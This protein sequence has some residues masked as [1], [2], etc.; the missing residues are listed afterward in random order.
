MPITKIV[1][2]GQTGADQ[3]ALEAAVYCSLPY[4]GWIPKGRK[5]EKGQKV[6]TKFDQLREMMTSDYL[7]RTE[8]NVVDSDATLVLTYGKATGGSKKTI[9]FAEKH[10]KPVL[11]IGIDQYSPRDCAMFV[12]RWFEGD[13]TKPTPPDNCTLN[14]AGSRESKSPGIQHDVMN[15]I[16]EVIS[17]VNGTCFY[18]IQRSKPM[19][20][21][22]EE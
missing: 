3:G 14:V 8:A 17:V 1:S 19:I 22:E 10:G 9:E 6:P 16:I 18:P 4:G 13:I 15:V 11:H 21:R 2:G 20:L 5:A 12:K 7:A